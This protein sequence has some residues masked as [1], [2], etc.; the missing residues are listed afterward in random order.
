MYYLLY[1]SIKDFYYV[2]YFLLLLPSEKWEAN[3]VYWG[4]TWFEIQT[5]PKAL[6]P[7]KYRTHLRILESHCAIEFQ[8]HGSAGSLKEGPGIWRTKTT[9]RTW[10][11]WTTRGSM[12]FP[13]KARFI[14]TSVKYFRAR[15]LWKIASSNLSPD[16]RSARSPPWW[17]AASQ[18]EISTFS[19]WKSPFSFLSQISP[20]Y[21]SQ[22][23]TL[24]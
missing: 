19:L 10:E 14:L 3:N 15:Q 24:N 6:S 12:F 5:N 13:Q 17:L 11:Q 23:M 18:L 16:W 22:K 21:F 1:T 4:K 20:P 9:L 7:W 8:A 2:I